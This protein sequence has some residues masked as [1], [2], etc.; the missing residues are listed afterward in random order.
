MSPLGAGRAKGPSCPHAAQEAGGAPEEG[1]AGS[2]ARGTD[3]GKE[4]KA[5][6]AEDP[7]E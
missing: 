6:G 4:E 1:P 5:G 2:G 7:A 3:G